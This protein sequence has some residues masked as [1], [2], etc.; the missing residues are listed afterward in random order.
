MQIVHSLSLLYERHTPA[1]HYFFHNCLLRLCSGY[2]EYLS[3][4]P[5]GWLYQ[6]AV[7]TNQYIYGHWA[8]YVFGSRNGHAGLPV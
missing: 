6:V 7:W 5:G 2:F 1:K 8:D 4:Y 3:F